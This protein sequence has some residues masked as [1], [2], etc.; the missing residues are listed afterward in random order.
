M[1]ES[2]IKCPNECQLACDMIEYFETKVKPELEAGNLAK[3]FRAMFHLVFLMEESVYSMFPFA[4]GTNTIA[5]AKCILQEL[6]A[7]KTPSEE[8]VTEFRAYLAQF[9]LS[10][11]SGNRL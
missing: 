10:T 2:D 11:I 8:T 5:S 9:K 1:S 3:G 6:R 4:S 7:D